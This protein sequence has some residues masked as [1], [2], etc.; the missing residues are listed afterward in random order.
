MANRVAVAPTRA[1]PLSLAVLVLVLAPALV[2][3]LARTLAPLAPDL[4]PTPRLELLVLFSHSK[5]FIVQQ[6]W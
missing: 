3:D 1:P 2:R 6:N 4:D 5:L